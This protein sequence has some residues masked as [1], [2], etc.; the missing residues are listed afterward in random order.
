MSNRFMIGN[1]IWWQ[2]PSVV[3][4]CPQWDGRYFEDDKNLA[5]V[6][7]QARFGTEKFTAYI[8]L[9]S[10]S[11]PQSELKWSFHTEG[12]DSKET[13]MVWCGD[14]LDMIWEMNGEDV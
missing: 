7:V 12:F 9:R 13:A 4:E 6:R 2:T 10:D 1:V 14:Q 11:E 3:R 5:E 8:S